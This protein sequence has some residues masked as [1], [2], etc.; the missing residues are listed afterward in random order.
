MGIDVGDTQEADGKNARTRQHPVPHSPIRERGGRRRLRRR[1]APRG[2][3]IVEATPLQEDASKQ[4]DG[5][6]RPK[7]TAP[8]GDVLRRQNYKQLRRGMAGGKAANGADASDDED[9]FLDKL[10]L[11]FAEDYWLAPSNAKAVP[12]PLL[13]AA[14]SCL[15]EGEEPARVSTTKTVDFE[16]WMRVLRMGFSLLVQGVGSKRRLL[17]T[18]A[19]TK[20]VPWGAAVIRI[21]GF[22]AKLSL[23]ECL[24]AVQ[25]LCPTG[26]H[27][28]SASIE[29]L[30]ASIRV[31]RR[32]TTE[33]LRPL[34]FVV[35]NLENL[36][37]AHQSVLSGLIA[38]PGVYLVASVDDIWADL[39]WAP[40]CRKEFNFVRELAH[41]FES[42]EAEVTA[43][44]PN[45]LP[46]WADPAAEGK[47]VTKTSLGVVL[48]SLTQ[49]HRDLVKALAEHQLEAGGRTG[50]TNWR[51]LDTARDRMIALDANRLKGLLRELQDHQV[52]AQRGATDGVS[53]LMYLTCSTKVLQKLAEGDD[54][55]LSDEE[56]S[57]GEAGLT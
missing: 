47:A 55:E 7:R 6:P 45:G 42:Y 16:A 15:P 26:T 13:K 36:T 20:L 49:T 48:R 9:T 53:T 18:F 11:G 31:S 56:A 24:R 41:T 51:L 28:G 5:Q 54:I 34:C 39:N 29:V 35:H 46:S 40:R 38:V 37:P 33:A 30:A 43:R 25:L 1:R 17:E 19:D 32:S 4:E 14:G 50:I 57:G 21:N 22:D 23:L 12:A 2:V 8:A 3:G 27:T 52:I 10:K 44:Y